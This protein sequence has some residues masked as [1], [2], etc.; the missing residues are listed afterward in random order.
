[1][2]LYINSYLLKSAAEEPLLPLYM[3]PFWVYTSYV[4]MEWGF[5]LSAALLFLFTLGDRA[6]RAVPR[7]ARVLTRP[8]TLSKNMRR[9]VLLLSIFSGTLFLLLSER[10]Y[11]PIPFLTSALWHALSIGGPPLN[12]D[13]STVAFPLGVVAT[14]GFMVYRLQTGFISSLKWSLKVFFLP[15]VLLLTVGLWLHGSTEMVLYVTKFT[16]WSFGSI[17]FNSGWIGLYLL[18]NW[19]VLTIAASFF[20]ILVLESLRLSVSPSGA[21]AEH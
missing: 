10:V 9:V 6:L 21:G 15:V 16:A 4:E 17:D 14:L 1:V 2:T 3:D 7:L 5:M 12:L 11:Y 13:P 18:S 8:F 20:L 19:T